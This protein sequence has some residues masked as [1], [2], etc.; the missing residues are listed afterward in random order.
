MTVGRF[1]GKNECSYEGERAQTGTRHAQFRCQCGALTSCDLVTSVDTRADPEV[2]LVATERG[3]ERGLHRVTCM[4]CGTSQPSPIPFTYHDGEQEVFALVLPEGARCSELEERANLLLALAKES[5]GVPDYVVEPVVVYGPEGL[6][7]FLASRMS[8]R[9]E[10][11]RNARRLR[12]VELRLEGAAEREERISLREQELAAMTDDLDGRSSQLTEKE[13]GLRDRKGALDRRTQELERMA[14]AIETAK[15]QLRAESQGDLP[16]ALQ[17]DATEALSIDDIL[18]SAPS[19]EGVTG[20]SSVSGASE[21]N[22]S[23]YSQVTQEPAPSLLTGVPRVAPAS[24][25]G[26]GKVRASSE[27]DTSEHT[28]ISAHPGETSPDLRAVQAVPAL[29]SLQP[30]DSSPFPVQ[31]LAPKAD[32]G[33]Q[34]V[35][36]PSTTRREVQAWRKLKG[37]Q[38]KV[39]HTHEVS[40]V[41]SLRPGS[42]EE[43]L[44]LDIRVLLQ[45]HR[46]PTYPLISL[47]LARATTLAGQPGRP[48]SFHFDVGIPEERAILAQLAE[49]FRFKLEL[50]DDEHRPI[51]QRRLAAPLAA[52]IDYVLALATNARKELPSDLRNFQQAVKAFESSRYDRLGRSHVLARDFKDSL[53]DKLDDPT[54]L[55]AAIEQCGLFSTPVGEEYLVAIRSYPFGRWHKRRL[56]I[57]RRAMA[58]GLWMG[59]DLAR[60]AVSEEL[61]HSRRDL[62]AQCE[63][64]FR[65]LSERAEQGLS[66]SCSRANWSALAAEREALG[67]TSQKPQQG[68]SLEAK[69]P[70]VSPP[71]AS[72]KEQQL[73]AQLEDPATRLQ[74]IVGLCE[75]DGFAGIGSVFRALAQLDSHQGAEAF[76]AITNLGNRAAESLLVLLSC[77]S[78]HLRHGATL[79]L[80]EL[81]S[82]EGIDS[83]CESLM[84]SEGTIWREYAIAIGRV[85]AP[86]VMP[87]VARIGKSGKRGQARAVWGLAYLARGGASGPVETLARGRDQVV[88]QVATASLELRQRLA[89]KTIQVE[90]SAA[91]QEFTEAFLGA[92]EG[93]NPGFASADLSGPAM[94]LDES[95][96]IEA[97]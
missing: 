40:L 6:S 27:I 64:N 69:L 18:S 96:L 19:P 54:D 63:V 2:A 29:A 68:E 89:D 24:G 42:L 15:E 91:E 12:D 62:L 79:A 80:C 86:A 21:T 37:G 25:E 36:I 8:E 50:F 76:A 78:P 43:L 56:E 44:A 1:T 87:L 73:L 34:E 65:L 77:P 67:A 28:E 57:I 83:T 84:A 48:F 94:L 11:H 52:N 61:V 66:E 90:R 32:I 17:G 41:A 88:S 59:A 47:T 13:L 60:V 31:P 20:V 26:G 53:L 23:V 10:Q 5:E 71:K 16:E 72:S 51:R 39:L 97:T 35:T 92:L 3:V 81:G 45:L 30:G 9:D 33:D 46:M 95:D 14:L 4:S 74:A 22:N 75:I 38:L 55:L 7:E 93:G 58:C 85:G 70:R 49:D 82:E